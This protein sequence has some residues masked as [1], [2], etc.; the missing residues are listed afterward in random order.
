MKFIRFTPVAYQVPAGTALFI[1]A[2]DTE[3][4]LWWLD[5]NEQQPGPKWRPLPSHPHWRPRTRRKRT[6]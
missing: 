3:G 5:T 1:V 2:L 6:G 4:E